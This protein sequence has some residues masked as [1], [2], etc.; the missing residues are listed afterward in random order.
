MILSL[1][2]ILPVFSLG[3]YAGENIPEP[4]PKDSDKCV[5]RRGRASCSSVLPV[6]FL[7]V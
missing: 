7:V 5:E 3:K 4:H 6:L 1:V 2:V